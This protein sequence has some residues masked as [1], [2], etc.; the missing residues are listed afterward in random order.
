MRPLEI[1][2]LHGVE[3]ARHQLLQLNNANS[4]ET[5]LLTRDLFDR[6]IAAARVAVFIEPDD[7]FLL[8]F[9]QTDQYDGGHFQWFRNRFDTFLYIERVVV[10]ET[11]RRHGLGRLLYA[12]LFQRAAQLGH[13]KIVCE[14]N[15]EPPNPVSA[16]FHAANGFLEVGTAT[17]DNGAKTV[18]YLLRQQ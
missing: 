5:S 6:M 8:A 1:K 7:A 12:D 14:V 13:S 17:F 16:K 18:R 9:E 4:V 11:Q 3:A 10:A 2:D 15:V